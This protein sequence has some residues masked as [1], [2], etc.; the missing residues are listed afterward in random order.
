MGCCWRKEIRNHLE[1]FS[2][3]NLWAHGITNVRSLKRKG[4]FVDIFFSVTQN[5]LHLK[6][7]HWIICCTFL[8]IVNCECQ[9]HSIKR[10]IY[11]IFTLFRFY[12]EK[13]HTTVPSG[14][15]FRWVDSICM[16]REFAFLTLNYTN[17]IGDADSP[18]YFTPTYQKEM[19]SC[20]PGTVFPIY[21]L[22]EKIV[23]LN[24]SAE[25][26]PSKKTQNDY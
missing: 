10:S 1:I 17:C 13:S 11:F 24:Q 15:D 14:M 9:V 19:A 26:F 12:I 2:I 3:W 25:M 4:W 18:Y 7:T 23:G 5:L 20:L 16:D 6:W 21:S 22:H 8:Q